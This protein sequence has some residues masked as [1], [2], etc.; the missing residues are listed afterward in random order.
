MMMRKERVTERQA[1]RFLYTKALA[2]APDPNMNLD[3]YKE[4]L[5]VSES[6]HKTIKQRPLSWD[7]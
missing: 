5:F 1:L 2:G 3:A 6:A 7:R 4:R